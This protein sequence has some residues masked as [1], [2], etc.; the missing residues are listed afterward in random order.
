[1]KLP[2]QIT[3][4]NMPPSPAIE[5]AVRKKAD[6]LDR[7]SKHIMACRVVVEAPHRR[8]H[9][10]KQYHVRIDL[11]V[12]GGELAVSR[13]PALHQAHEDVY[14]AIRDAFDAAA[15]QLEDHTRRQRGQTKVHATEPRGRIARLVPE[16]DFGFIETS[17]GREIFFHRHSVLGE[18][19]DRLELGDDVNFV[20]EPGDKGPQASTVRTVARRR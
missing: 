7:F 5:A 17:D 20:E 11:T 15:R 10:G 2:L 16:Q 13:E 12:P 18:E 19:F 1:M 4:R 6:R 3:F 8:H 9:Q 14:V